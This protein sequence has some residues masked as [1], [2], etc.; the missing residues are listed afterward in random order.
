MSY[1]RSKSRVKELVAYY[2]YLY[3]N[4]ERK[5]VAEIAKYLNMSEGTVRNFIN[6]NYKGRNPLGQFSK[7]DIIILTTTKFGSESIYLEDQKVLGNLIIHRQ[8]CRLI[9]LQEK[10]LEESVE[11][12][13]TKTGKGK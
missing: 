8:T 5:S 9:K 3:E 1:Y 13:K 11:K 10:K 6:N 2:K 4:Y 12:V 7:F